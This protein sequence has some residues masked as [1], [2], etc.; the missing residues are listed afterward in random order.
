MTSYAK[1]LH[2]KYYTACEPKAR[3]LK[4]GNAGNAKE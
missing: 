4:S 2:Y 1:V 3:N